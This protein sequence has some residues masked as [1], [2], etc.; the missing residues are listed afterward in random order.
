VGTY[1][2][3]TVDKLVKG[4]LCVACGGKLTDEDKAGGFIR[5]GVCR[6]DLKRHVTELREERRKAGLCLTCGQPKL[7]VSPYCHTC[8]LGV[9]EKKFDDD[10]V[11]SW[12]EFFDELVKDHRRLFKRLHDPEKANKVRDPQKS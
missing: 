5:C 9:P 6:E 10:D 3:S 7:P 8:A 4:R 12:I 2:N 11:D 1:K